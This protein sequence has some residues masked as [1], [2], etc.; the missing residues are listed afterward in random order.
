VF[1]TG[2]ASILETA[3]IVLWDVA[4]VAVVA[5][6]IYGYVTYPGDGR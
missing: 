4:L 2:P 1:I 6:M 3:L 5:I